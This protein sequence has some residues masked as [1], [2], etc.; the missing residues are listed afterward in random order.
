[1]PEL[2]CEIDSP[3]VVLVGR[4]NPAIFQ[5][6]WFLANGLLPKEEAEKAEVRIISP[7]V[8]ELGTDWFRLLVL[9]ERFSAIT[10]D[11]AR[12]PALRDLVVETFKLLEHTPLQSMGINRAQ[13]FRMESA[14]GW[15]KVGH[16]LAP[17]EPWK[18]LLVEPGTC[19]VAVQ[20]RLA[21]TAHSR[22]TVRVEPSSAVAPYGVLVDTNEHHEPPGA[23]AQALVEILEQRWDVAQADSQR[24]AKEL[25]CRAMASQS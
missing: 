13:H 9:P 14:E 5:P 15:H 3:S 11:T 17:K 25:L 2:T 7:Q 4:L 20:G 1:M 10:L 6:S 21:V 16:F 19:S 18:D 8:T 24:I 23:T 22:L 12:Q